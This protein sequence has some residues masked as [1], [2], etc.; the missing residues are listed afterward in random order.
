MSNIIGFP[1]QRC[2]LKDQVAI[3]GSSAEILFFTGVRYERPLEPGIKAA[4]QVGIK[5]SRMNRSNA[6][7]RS[8]RKRKQQA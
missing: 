1:V 8:P 4:V 3:V 2:V 6:G 5:P 7:V